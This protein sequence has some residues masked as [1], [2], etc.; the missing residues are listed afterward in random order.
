MA[1]RSHR[2][3]L[4]ALF[5]VLA[6]MFAGIAAAAVEGRVWVVAFAGAVLALWLGGMAVRALR[7]PQ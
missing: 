6:L 7:S 2:R 1:R 5:L 3:P 4:G